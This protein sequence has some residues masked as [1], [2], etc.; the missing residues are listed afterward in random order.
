MRSANTPSTPNAPNIDSH[1]STDESLTTNELMSHTLAT[2]KAKLADTIQ[3]TSQMITQTDVSACSTHM[4]T[5]QPV[6]TPADTCGLFVSHPTLY[7]SS[8]MYSVTHPSC[9]NCIQSELLIAYAR[10]TPYE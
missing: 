8:V 7:C 6:D 3:E 1:P 9:S 5:L 2:S 4:H 10:I